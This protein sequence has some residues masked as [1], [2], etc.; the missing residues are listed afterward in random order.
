MFTIINIGLFI[1]N[2]KKVDS[3]ICRENGKDYQRVFD[4]DSSALCPHL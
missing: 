3:P 2:T 1:I 4:T